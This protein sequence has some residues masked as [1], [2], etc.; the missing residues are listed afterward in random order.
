MKSVFRTN[1]SGTVVRVQLGDGVQLGRG[2]HLGH[3]V[4][5]AADTVIC[6]GRDVR[7]YETLGIPHN[8]QLMI[9]AGCRWYTAA[10]ALAHWRDN[11][12]M[13][14]KVH[15]IVSEFKRK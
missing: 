10:Q 15:Y 11:T 4:H 2:V 13:T 1:L 12:E 14:A 8:G 3:G 9:T 7:W 6:A 5:L